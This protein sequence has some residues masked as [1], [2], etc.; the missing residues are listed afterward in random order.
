MRERKRRLPNRSACGAKRPDFLCRHGAKR[1]AAFPQI[2][3]SS[4]L[5]TIRRYTRSTGKAQPY[6][7]EVESRDD[8]FPFSS[9]LDR[10]ISFP[11]GALLEID[12]RPFVP[13]FHVLVL[14]PQKDIFPDDCYPTVLVRQTNGLWDTSSLKYSAWRL[15]GW[16][17]PTLISPLY[18]ARSIDAAQLTPDEELLIDARNAL[19]GDSERGIAF[20]NV[21]HD[22]PSDS[23]NNDGLR[24][25][26]KRFE[27]S[28]KIN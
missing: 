4:N 15:F 14:E 23:L 12:L 7:K 9:Q 5:H 26:I 8:D 6:F 20:W 24:S 25:L 21:L 10:H 22:A 27:E 17:A 16:H 19:G 2:R 11:T 1:P 13:P 3:G 28:Y 18:R